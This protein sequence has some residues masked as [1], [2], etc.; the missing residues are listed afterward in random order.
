MLIYPN[1]PSRFLR[2]S[3]QDFVVWAMD[4]ET[5]DIHIQNE[6]K[7]IC[8]IHGKKHR[9][10]NKKLSKQELVDIII[11]MHSDGAITQLHA[12]GYMD[13]SWSFKINRNT[14]LRARVN[15]TLMMIEGHKGYQI[16]MR[17]IKNDPLDIKLLKL[18]QEV[19]SNLCHKRG[20]ALVV[21]STGSGKSTFLASVIAWRL[22]Q[23][24][25]HLKI[26]TIE[27]PI[28]FIY[29]N[30]EK[31]TSFISQTEI[32]THLASF[33]LG[34]RNAFRRRSDVVLIG[35]MRDTETIR[36]GLKLSMAGQLV[37]S[38]LHSNGVAEVPSRMALDFDRQEKDA[39]ITEILENLKIIIAQM[40]VP[41]T[42]GKRIAIREYLIMNDEIVQEILSVGIDKMSNTMKKILKEHGHTFLQDAKEKL[43]QGLITKEVF[44][45]L[46]LT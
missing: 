31:P 16:T 44:K 45:S 7:I 38:T 40:L 5:S 4:N 18:P 33:N 42:D 9:V 25:S 10:T 21:G 14:Y 32:G 37:Y 39:R 36:E 43:E 29:D 26:I 6:D 35:E 34:A 17:L 27:D 28:E 3:L 41:C 46:R 20:L 13:F 24:N 23:L 12:N 1:E 15:I 8:E 19:L 2:N 30:I 11:G 22:Q